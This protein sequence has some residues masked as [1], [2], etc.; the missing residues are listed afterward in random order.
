MVELFVKKEVQKQYFAIVDGLLEKEGRMEHFLVPKAS[1]D[2][3]TLFAP[4]K[5]KGGKRAITFWQCFKRGK[6]AS[7]AL[8]EPITGRTHQIRV[9]F[10]ASS[11]PILGDWQYAQDFSCNYRPERHLLHSYQVNFIHPITNKKVKVIAE[12]PQDFLDAQAALDL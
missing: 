9:Q 6:D 3:G 4:A 12:L 7:L 11:H 1:Y 8:V 10:N 2:G 5:N